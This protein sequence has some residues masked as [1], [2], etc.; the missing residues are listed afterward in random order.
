MEDVLSDTPALKVK[1]R[2]EFGK[3]KK[4]RERE[5]ERQRE[6]EMNSDLTFA[7]KGAIE[8]VRKSCRDRTGLARFFISGREGK[9][10]Q[11]KKSYS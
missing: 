6:K 1:R 10:G 8:K 2:K 3:K 5:R 11:V 9:R 4:E 7:T